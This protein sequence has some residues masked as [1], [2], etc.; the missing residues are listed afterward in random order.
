M[1]SFYKEILSAWQEIPSTDPQTAS[2]Y[3]NEIIWNNRFTNVEGKPVFFRHGIIN[4][5]VIKIRDLLND[6]RKF[7]CRSKFQ[8]KYGLEVNFLKYNGLLAVIPKGWNFFFNSEQI[9][10][11]TV[12][13]I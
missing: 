1:P 3:E 5:G 9:S 10:S 8:E 6:S 7:L 11:N 4:K 12:D 2:E 13:K